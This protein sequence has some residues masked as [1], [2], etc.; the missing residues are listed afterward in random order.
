M[1][2][3]DTNLL[4]DSLS[5]ETRER[6]FS[7]CTAVPLPQKTVLYQPE[8]Q[9]RYGFFLTSGFAS[10]VTRMEEGHSAE[11]GM[12]GFEGLVGS[13]QLLGPGHT[14]SECFMQSDG[15]GL[16]IPF[17]KLQEAFLESDPI[18]Q[19][20]L[21]FVQSQAHSAAQISACHRLHG[22]EERLA[23]WLLMVRDRVKSDT[24]GLTQEFLAEMLGAR[25]TTV[26]LV[27]GALQRGGLIE[28]SRGRVCIL[29]AENLEAAACSCYPII[30]RFES[31]LYSRPLRDPDALVPA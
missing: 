19:R 28:Y 5:A 27:A 20:V 11:V 7:Q 18:R 4:L 31:N 22:A 10:V 25:R 2:S 13:L 29:N 30:R 17:I 8:Q 23:R 14:S 12:I 1:T 26:T 9:P 16:R 6:L 3:P 24:L 15:A 21:E